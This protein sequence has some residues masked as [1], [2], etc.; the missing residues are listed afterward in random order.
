VPPNQKICPRALTHG[1]QGTARQFRNA[2][3]LSGGD[4]QHGE[5]YLAG[6]RLPAP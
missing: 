6:A 2:P 1:C 3:K 4:E 5:E